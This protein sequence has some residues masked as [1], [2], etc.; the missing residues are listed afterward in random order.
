MK[1][2]NES[3]QQMGTTYKGAGEPQFLTT[4]APAIRRQLA[5][6][7]P[8]RDPKMRQNEQHIWVC[9]I[10]EDDLRRG[11]MVNFVYYLLYRC[12]YERQV[13]GIRIDYIKKQRGSTTTAARTFRF[14]SRNQG[15]TIF[16]WFGKPKCEFFKSKFRFPKLLFLIFKPPSKPRFEPFKPAYH[17]FKPPWQ[18]FQIHSTHN[19][20][21]WAC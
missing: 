11:H 1:R 15:Q 7:G 13:C 21:S 19:A 20:Q 14:S 6:D 9:A 18:G 2:L 4:I 12:A 16:L 3:L 17:F 8:N 5:S 10:C